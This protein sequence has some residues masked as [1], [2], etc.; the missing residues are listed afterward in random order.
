MDG[1]LYTV[2]EVSRRLRLCRAVVRSMCRAGAIR[3]RRH[4]G[5]WVIE[6]IPFTAVVTIKA[7][8]LSLN[9]SEQRTRE[10]CREG[11]VKAVK[12]G[13]NWRIDAEDM[14]KLIINWTRG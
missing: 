1:R 13:H 3:A 11:V 8:A 9:I 2:P 14:G 7:L 6:E 5:A 12:V 4:R 10:L